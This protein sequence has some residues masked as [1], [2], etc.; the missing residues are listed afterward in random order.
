MKINKIAVIGSGVMGAGIAAHIANAGFEV[1]LL[2][3]VSKNSDDRNEFTKAAITKLLVSK[4]PAFV[5]SSFATRIIP[6][7]LEDDLEKLKDIDWII[8]VIVEKLSIKQELYKKID[9]VRKKKSIISSNTSTLPLKNLVQGMSAKFH[10]DF[11]ITHFFNP[12][13]YMKLLEFVSSKETNKDKIKI[14]REFLSFSLGKTVVICKDTP[15]FIANRIGCFWLEVALSEALKTNL[16]VDNIDKVMG[17][18]LFIPRTAVFGLWDLIGIDLMPLIASS[19]LNVLSKKDD[20]PKI[21]KKHDLI[22]KMINEGYTGRKGKGGFYKITKNPNGSKQQEV[23]DLKTGEYKKLIEKDLDIFKLSFKDLMLNDSELG[24]YVRIVMLQVLSYAA[25]LVPE[26]SN[27]I[28]SIDIAIKAGYSWKKGPFELIDMIGANNFAKMLVT[29]KM[30]VPNIIKKIGKN[31]FYLEDKFFT[32]N[33]SYKIIKKEKELLQLSDYSNKEIISNK[34]AVL[35]D[36]GNKIACFNIRT[37][38]NILSKEVF[39]LLSNSIDLLTKRGFKALVIGNDS[40]NFSVG[41]NLESML[42]FITKKDFLG[43]ENY[44]K[45]GQETIYKLKYASFPT[46]SAHRGIAFGGGCELLLH[47]SYII[48]EIEASF[49]LV[50]ARIGLI[51]AWG[52]V[53]E[54]VLRSLN[55]SDEVICNA[56]KNILKGESFS[57]VQMDNQ[58]FLS[59]NDLIMNS[60]AIIFDAKIKALSLSKSYKQKKSLSA[61]KIDFSRRKDFLCDYLSEIANLSVHEKKIGKKLIDIFA[62]KDKISEELLFELE[63]EAFIELSK[64]NDTEIKIRGIIK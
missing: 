13:R 59:K 36:F 4:P 42:S 51:P 12:P 31:K 55:K 63:R 27:D 49:G 39:E 5:D 46:V 6:G 20:F 48:S 10:E 44:I 32:K 14:M 22:E 2:D 21:Y 64:T 9:L 60:E 23:I 52:G 58:L 24:K 53:K 38:M 47:S 8:E 57:A 45:L 56:F 54:T 30:E 29:E 50:E 34:D 40:K 26:I 19:M 37:K 1:L 28:V 33:D 35:Y 18:P 61:E 25:K 15:G 62:P 43:L 41:G 7:N 17:E 16:S 3:I 11:M